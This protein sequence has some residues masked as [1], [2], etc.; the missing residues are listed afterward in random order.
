MRHV[1]YKGRVAAAGMRRESKLW[2][3]LGLLGLHSFVFA[4][5]PLRT[6][7]KVGLHLL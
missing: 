6:L 3:A 5:L 2:A 7:W 1:T 4:W